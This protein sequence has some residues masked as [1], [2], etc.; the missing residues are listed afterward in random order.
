M[1]FTVKN[2]GAALTACQLTAI[3]LLLSYAL[4]FAVLW[5]GAVLAV[6]FVLGGFLIY[7][8]LIRSRIFV[9]KTEISITKGFFLPTAFR[10]PL[11]FISACHIIQTPLQRIIGSC[12][13][14]LITSGTFAVIAGLSAK[15]ANA[16]YALI[17]ERQEL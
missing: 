13:C 15:D 12:Y 4:S 5:V 7:L 2:K 9:D 10:V 17:R 16:M 3:G 11:R 14:V 1:G 8:R 6:G